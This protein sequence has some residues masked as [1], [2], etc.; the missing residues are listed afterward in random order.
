MCLWLLLQ[1]AVGVAAQQ[2]PPPL[3]SNASACVRCPSCL[4]D[5]FDGCVGLPVLA[6]HK[7]CAKSRLL[8]GRRVY[9]CPGSGLLFTHPTLSDDEVATLYNGSKASQRQGGGA[10]AVAQ[11]LF[12][13]EAALALPHLA[14]LPH[15]ASVVEMGCTDTST[16]LLRLH[17]SLMPHSTSR[18]RLF[19]YNPSARQRGASTI[20]SR[21]NEL[22]VSVSIRVFGQGFDPV[23]HAE[24]HGLID[25]FL[26]S[27]VLEQCAASQPVG[28]T[29]TRCRASQMA[30]QPRVTPAACHPV[31]RC[32][33][34][35]RVGRARRVLMFVCVCACARVCVCVC[36]RACVWV[37][38]RVCARARVCVCVCV[39]VSLPDLCAFL[40]ALYKA[41]APG[42][43]VFTETPY[44]SAQTLQHYRGWQGGLFHLSLPDV[45]G[46]RHLMEAAGFR[47][48]L[49]QKAP[50]VKYTTSSIH[51]GADRGAPVIRSIFFKPLRV[52]SG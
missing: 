22:N 46:M 15:D 36:V 7:D 49:I 29:A 28:A 27:H 9:E 6:V 50:P 1:P 41:M 17:G 32:A 38:T 26:S 25:F 40:E 3:E 11:L 47:L 34:S 24:R 43:V 48:G 10:R 13:A 31:T 8:C 33:V 42:G 18:R 52:T 30:P 16:S 35:Q 39:L 12:I 45:D 23:A 51:G 37:C 20:V 2:A 44:Q 19:C 4:K 21:K 14:R 5:Q